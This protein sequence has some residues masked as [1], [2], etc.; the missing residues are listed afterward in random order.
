MAP[1]SSLARVLLGVLHASGTLHVTAPVKLA[2]TVP[3]ACVLVSIVAS[4]TAQYVTSARPWKQWQ[5]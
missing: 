2:V 3:R 5:Q 4:A 1:Q